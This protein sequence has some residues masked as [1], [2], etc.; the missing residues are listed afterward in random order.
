MY[1]SVCKHCHKVFKSRIRT[2]CCNDCRST[3]EN[4]FDDIVEYLRR[5]PNSNAVQI[6]EE[7]GISAY[8]VL[9]FLEEGRLEL[10]RGTFSRLED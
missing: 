1:T 4:C 5:F 6:A 8:V 3:D 9:K 2:A 7:L 10:S